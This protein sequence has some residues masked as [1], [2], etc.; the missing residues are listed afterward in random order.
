VKKLL[1]IGI[2][3]HS[4]AHEVA[5]IPSL[6]FEKPGALWRKVK[7]ITI[8]N[9][10]DD[11]IFLDSII[12]EQV[13]N[14]GDVIIAVDHTGGYYS[15]PI[16]YFLI[17][18]GYDVYYLESKGVKAARERLLDQEIKSDA[19]DSISAAYMLYLR[20][21][22]G[23]SFRISLMKYELGSQAAVIKSLILQRAHINKLIMQLTN[24]LHQLLI[25]TFPEG[26]SRYFKK[27][28]QII[29]HYSTPQYICSSNNLDGV[30]CLKTEDRKNIIKLA[31]TS[32]GVPGDTYEWVI[33]ELGKLR[34]DLIKKRET[35]T[36]M[37][38]K[39]LNSHDYSEIL[40]SFPHI[41][42]ITAGTIIGIIKD[43]DNWPNKKKFKKALGVYSTLKQSGTKYRGKRGRE[44]SKYGRCAL[45]H[46]CRGCVRINAVENDFKDYYLR[47]VAQGKM[48]MKALVSTMGK[49]AEIMYHCLKH[50]ELYKYQGIYRLKS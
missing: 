25:A 7:T 19:I 34:L 11:F 40:L 31:T 14:K 36:L 26:E 48:R 50:K 33:K 39:Q 8:R 43:I 38:H 41:G 28:L 44:G 22:Q 49:L 10:R 47:Q 16:V 37:I 3:I 42:E 17:K 20:D 24:K 27:L 13:N 4:R 1:Y 12:K 5:I 30:E 46:V 32:I 29:G 23:L 15:E 2:D 35:I 45:F 21:T 6:I 18:G 9:N